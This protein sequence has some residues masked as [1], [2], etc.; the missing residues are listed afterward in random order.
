MTYHYENNMLILANLQI[1]IDQLKKCQL[2]YR[3][4]LSV[5]G[6]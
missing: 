3:Q 5:N 4:V 2:S 6:E 1:G